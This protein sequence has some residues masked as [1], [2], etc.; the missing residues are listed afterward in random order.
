MAPTCSLNSREIVSPFFPVLCFDVRGLAIHYH[1]VCLKA[2]GRD[3]APAGL[4][5]TLL[6]AYLLLACSLVLVFIFFSCVFDFSCVVIESS[7]KLLFM[8]T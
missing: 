5:T 4:I 7:L 6:V 2:E 8:P 3:G 1:I